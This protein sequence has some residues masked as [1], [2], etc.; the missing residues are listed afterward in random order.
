MRDGGT[1]DELLAAIPK[2]QAPIAR[3]SKTAEVAAVM[4]DVAI[5]EELYNWFGIILERYDLPRGFSGTFY[6]AD[7]DYFRFVGHELLV[8][9]FAFLLREQQWDIISRLLGEPIPVRYIR[10]DNGPGNAEWSDVSRHVGILGGLSRNHQRLSM[11]GDI[12]NERHT[13]GELAGIL[14]FEEFADADFFLYLRGL[15]PEDEFTGHFSWRPWSAVWLRGIPR[16]LLRAQS[17][18]QAENVSRAL[19]LSSVAELRNRLPQR[20]HQLRVLYQEGWWEYPIRQ[21]DIEKIGSR[22][23]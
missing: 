18:A 5:A 23:P 8:T 7:F 21:A 1:G 15:L 20:G 6:E 14:P 16:F 12:L 9:L 3:F 10:R 17:E 2:T 13:K 22:K 4:G 11:H 19:S